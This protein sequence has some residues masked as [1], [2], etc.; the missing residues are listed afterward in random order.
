MKRSERISKIE[1][2]LSLKQI[3]VVWLANIL[4][5]HNCKEYLWYLRGLTEDQ[6]PK[7]LLHEGVIKK[8][9]AL[10]LDKTETEKQIQQAEK[11]VAFLI[12]LHEYANNDCVTNHPRWHLTSGLLAEKYKA[13]KWLSACY[14]VMNTLD[15]HVGNKT[16]YPVEPDLAEVIC[17]AISNH[18]TPQDEIDDG[19]LESWLYKH[20]LCQGATTL[21]EGSYTYDSEDKNQPCLTENNEQ[22][23][24]ARFA[25]KMEFERF[26]AG[27][28]YTNGFSTVTDAEYRG[29]LNKMTSKLRKLVNTGTVSPGKTLFLN[30]I[31]IPFLKEVPL[32]QG[33]WA[34]R[35]AVELAELGAILEAEGYAA[36]TVKGHDLAWPQYS[37]KDGSIL[38]WDALEEYRRK[39]SCGLNHL[40]GQTKEINGRPYISIK[41]YSAWSGRMVKGDLVRDS[42]DGFVTSSWNAWLDSPISQGRLSGIIAHKLFPSISEGSFVVY[43]DDFSLRLQQRLLFPS[44]NNQENKLIQQEMASWRAVAKEFLTELFAF[45][46]AVGQ[47]RKKYFLGSEILFSDYVSDINELLEELERNITAFNHEKRMTPE[48]RLDIKLTRKEADQVVSA[49]QTRLV[50]L[51]QVEVLNMIGEE[52]MAAKILEKYIFE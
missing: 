10:G 21:P 17:A 29:S 31:P 20:L 7:R 26:K 25:N 34:D 22:L 42:C 32:V 43:R 47:I 51:A 39:A 30:T 15:F 5:H 16:P 2:H 35:Y 50:K 38:S 40:S 19:I 11:D 44:A 45:K 1:S 41:D 33:E 52:E 24:R 28:D 3:V 4:K 36:E 18:V 13:I 6:K 48:N 49:K 8:I 37:H 23:V 14:D 9:E 27:E 12:A 46:Q